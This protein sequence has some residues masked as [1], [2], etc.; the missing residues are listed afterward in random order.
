MNGIRDLIDRTLSRFTPEDRKAMWISISLLVISS[1]FTAF[2]PFVAGGFIDFLRET[3]GS[4][5]LMQVQTLILYSIVL[6]SLPVLGYVTRIHAE[7]D[8]IRTC[9]NFFRPTRAK[10]HEVLLRIP[11]AELETRYAGSI[12]SRL[13][14]D[15][16]NVQTLY[17]KTFIGLLVNLSMTS[18]VGVILVFTC[19]R[20]AWMAV[21]VIPAIVYVTVTQIKKADEAYMMQKVYLTDMNALMMEAVDAHRTIKAENMEGLLRDGFDD[22]NREYTEVSIEAGKRYARI[23]PST[24]LIGY[25]LYIVT[26]CVGTAL[27]FEKDLSLGMFIAFLSYFGMMSGPMKF[28]CTSLSDLN[29]QLQ[30]LD[31]IYELLDSDTEDI[32]EDS[33]KLD[34]SAM[35]GKVVFEDV[36]YSHKGV[37][38][39]DGISFT[40]EAGRF[41]TVIGPSGSGKSTLFNLVTRFYPPDRGRITVDG[42]DISTVSRSELSSCMGIVL[43]DPWIFDGTVIENI[44]YG[45]GDRT[46]EDVDSLLSEIGFDTFFG[47]FPKGLDTVIG[48][49]GIELPS[50]EK[51]MIALARLCLKNPR[52]IVLDE[53]FSGIDA[54]T[55]DM[56]FRNLGR[57][58]EGC[59]VIN[60]TYDIR[61]AVI[62]DRIVFMDE[63]RIVETGT[64]EGLM[65]LDGKYARMYRESFRRPVSDEPSRQ[66]T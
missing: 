24:F 11:L 41:T 9:A 29:N 32:V 7:R 21:L 43:Q 2:I 15:M 28:V 33:G 63:G 49:G 6:I 45:S 22:Y 40:A 5:G 52:I 35:E 59:T 13:S 66:R 61:H 12:T 10:I 25:A 47:S 65:A 23:E 55:T 60:F 14:N 62:S 53:A 42:I 39:V 26:A 46:R 4:G 64:H 18:I 17:T 20:L 51:K 1:L 34:G 50:A 48:K 58:F 27:V 37:R 30:S 36:C 56:M 19:P 31:R 16:V 8:L 44:M 38:A 54:L 3:A 57:R